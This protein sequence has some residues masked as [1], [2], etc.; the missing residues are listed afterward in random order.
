M[1]YRGVW[2]ATADGVAKSWTRLNN[3]HSV[4]LGLPRWCQW[5]RTRLT[6]AGYFRDLGSNP[7]SGRSP[8]EGN[9]NSLQHSW[10]ENPMNRGAWRSTVHGVTK[11][12]NTTQG[13]NNNDQK[14]VTFFQKHIQFYVGRVKGNKKINLLEMNLCNISLFAKILLCITKLSGPSVIQRER[15]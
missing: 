2:W 13:V 4:T 15:L 12:S 8:G 10:L 7:G 1:L 6:V 9:G 5:Q 3:Q 11:E 14:R